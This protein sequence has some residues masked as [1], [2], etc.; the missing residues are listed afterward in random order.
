MQE[1]FEHYFKFCNSAWIH[2]DKLVFEY[3]QYCIYYLFERNEE[4]EEDLEEE[5]WDDYYSFF[6]IDT[7]KDFE[8]ILSGNLSFS[9][10]SVRRIEF[11]GDREYSDDA[12]SITNE[13]YICLKKIISFFPNIIHST[14]VDVDYGDSM[15]ES[16]GNYYFSIE[17]KEEKWWDLDFGKFFTGVLLEYETSFKVPSFYVSFFN[18]NQ[19]IRDDKNISIIST[20]TKV[21]RLGYFK[22]L[23]W[24]VGEYGRVPVFSM[25]KKFENF[26]LSY[27]SSLDINKYRRGLVVESRTGVSAKPYIDVAVNMGLLTKINNLYHVGKNFKVYQAVQNQFSVKENVFVLD[28]FDRLYFLERIL[29][30]DYLYFSNLLELIFI[31][32]EIEYSRLLDLFQGKL[33]SRL[34]EFKESLY[35]Y[36][37]KVS[38]EIA[39]LITRIKSWDKPRVYLEHVL[40]PRLNWMLDL[41][42]ISNSF[43]TRYVLTNAGRK[44]FSHFAIWNDL[45]KSNIVSPDFFIDKFIVHLYDDCFNNGEIVNPVDFGFIENMIFKYVDDSFELFRTLAPNRV[46]ISQAANYAKYMLYF[47]DKIL[48]GYEFVLRVLKS[49]SRGFV[50]KY[51][52]QYK[53]GYIQKGF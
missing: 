44:V 17:I 21:R 7:S 8:R 26:C 1:V 13:L 22:V 10:F 25:N 53:D 52:E 31:E 18:R 47:S 41:G 20:N 29:K 28:D 4:L 9:S 37:I 5:Y 42:L 34:S 39:H 38:R 3:G 19:L 49:N 40:M 50:F 45:N 51:Q 24:F 27:Q 48:V 36:D 43:K 11:L 14:L 30:S 12:R 46:T 23:S 16:P 33:L 32:E 35:G 6:Y 15:C 2:E